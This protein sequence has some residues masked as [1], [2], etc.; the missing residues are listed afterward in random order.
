MGY[1]YETFNV[2]EQC[3]WTPEEQAAWQRQ[4]AEPWKAALSDSDSEEDLHFA[5]IFSDP[6]M[7]TLCE[8]REN[9]TPSPPSNQVQTRQ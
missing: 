2:D 5:E 4:Q 8:L 1:A 3:Q 6:A 9:E 7:R